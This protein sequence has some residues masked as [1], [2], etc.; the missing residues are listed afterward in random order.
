MEH[1]ASGAG[2]TYSTV[3]HIYTGIF[4]PSDYVDAAVLSSNMIFGADA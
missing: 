1:R 2:G 3:P 4:L